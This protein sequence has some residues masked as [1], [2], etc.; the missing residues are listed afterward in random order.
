MYAEK[1]IICFG[2]LDVKKAINIQGRSNVYPVPCGELKLL[3]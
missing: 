2:V 1:L 3:T